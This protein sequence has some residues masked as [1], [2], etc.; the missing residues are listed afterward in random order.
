MPIT[1]NGPLP[2]LTDVADGL[3]PVSGDALVYD[4]ETWT[5]QPVA[6]P[7][8]VSTLESLTN[9][10]DEAPAVVGEVLRWNGAAWDGVVPPPP[11]VPETLSNLTDVVDS[12]AP[13][14]DQVFTYDGTI[15]QWTA[16]NLPPP[17]VVPTLLAQLADVSDTAATSGQVLQSNGASWAPTDQSWV[18]RAGD[19]MSGD[20]RLSTAADLI[21]YRDPGLT[22]PTFRIDGQNGMRLIGGTAPTIVPLAGLGTGATTTVQWGNDEFMLITLNAGTSPAAATWLAQITLPTTRPSANYGVVVGS[23]SFTAPALQPFFGNRTT[24]S[25]QIGSV[26]APAASSAYSFALSI[27]GI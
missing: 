27:N 2:S 6:P 22:M 26:N 25:F 15:S 16:R 5:N 24:S 21:M 17:P 14:A 23:H 11:V 18:K 13:A 8:G 10:V 9:V 3:R 20:L 7:S 19:T 12:L 4:G 1:K